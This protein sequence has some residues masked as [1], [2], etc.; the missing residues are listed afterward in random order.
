MAPGNFVR[1]KNAFIIKCDSFEKNSDGSVKEIHCTYVPESRSGQDTSGIKTKGVIHWV[2]TQHCFPVEIRLYDRLFKVENP[3]AEDGDFKDYINPNSL[4]IISGAFAE[5]SLKTAKAGEKFQFLRKGYFCVDKDS[6][7]GKIIFNR[8]V[9][10]K[11]SWAQ[12]N[13][14]GK[15]AESI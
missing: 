8:T 6:T 2:D 12:E 1:L 4:E 5:P 11:D 13:T 10:L 15:I 9:A 7:S 14:K 3:S